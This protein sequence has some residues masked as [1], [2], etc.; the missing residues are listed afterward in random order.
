M[1]PQAMERDI[2]PTRRESRRAARTDKEPERKSPVDGIIASK[3]FR[4]DGV[5][6]RHALRAAGRGAETARR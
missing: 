3:R 5:D 2:R 4:S 1:A 6:H